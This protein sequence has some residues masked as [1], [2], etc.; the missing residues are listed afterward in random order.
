MLLSL[1]QGN[2]DIDFDGQPDFFW[3]DL[4]WFSLNFWFFGGGMFG[5]TGVIL[6]LTGRPFLTTLIAAALT[7][8]T[9]GSIITTTLR[10]LKRYTPN[11]LVT[12]DDL[13]GSIGTVELPFDHTQSGRVRLNLKGQQV[14][15]PARTHHSDTLEIGQTVVVVDVQNN[16]VHVVRTGVDKPKTDL[17]D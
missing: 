8:L 13:I 10:H 12:P 14:E 5:I 9:T 4:P 2:L 1:L 16:F 17:L 6:T 3:T 15:Y 7:G 11:S